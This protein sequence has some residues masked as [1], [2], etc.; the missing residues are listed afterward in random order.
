MHWLRC[1]G[2]DALVRS[3]PHLR[4]Q[5]DAI[6]ILLKKQHSVEKTTY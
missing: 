6:N 4:Q 3:G 1:A 2:F 5:A